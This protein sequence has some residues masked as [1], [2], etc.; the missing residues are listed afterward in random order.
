MALGKSGR[1]GAVWKAFVSMSILLESLAHAST[2]HN[3][4][5][6]LGHNVSDTAAPASLSSSLSAMEEINYQ[7]VLRDVVAAGLSKVPRSFGT[8][9][10][11]SRRAV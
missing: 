11:S 4:S 2:A 6:T 7:Q 9:A 1:I 5:I 3:A 8:E 10:P